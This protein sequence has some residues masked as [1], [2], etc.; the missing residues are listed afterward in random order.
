MKP[1][2]SGNLFKLQPLSP[3]WKSR[4]GTKGSNT[5]TTKSFHLAINFHL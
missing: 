5:P 4:G 1:L 2:A 3:P